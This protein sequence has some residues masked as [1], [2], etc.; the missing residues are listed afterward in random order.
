MEAI[1]RVAA[2]SEALF[3][4]LGSSSGLGADQLK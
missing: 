2:A 4:D 3:D 1:E